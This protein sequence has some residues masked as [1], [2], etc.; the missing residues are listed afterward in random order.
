MEEEETEI[1][2]LLPVNISQHDMIDIACT[3]SLAVRGIFI[4]RLIAQKNRPY[5]FLP[6]DPDRMTVSMFSV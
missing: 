6:A 3:F 1:W 4:I 2:D 5:V